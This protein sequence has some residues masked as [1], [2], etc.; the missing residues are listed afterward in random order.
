MHTTTNIAR[1]PLTPA[2]RSALEC[3]CID[4]D[5]PALRVS[6]SGGNLLWVAPEDKEQV[7]RELT[8]LANSEDA[9]Q[10]LITADAHRA[11]GARTA[12]AKLARTGR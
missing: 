2:Q 6:W 12:R 9:Q 10:L 1:I 8:D 5:T 11:R 3:A 4:D 7:A